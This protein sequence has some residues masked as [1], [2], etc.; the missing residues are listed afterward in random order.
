MH[1]SAGNQVKAPSAV[2]SQN[3][4]FLHTQNRREKRIHMN[5]VLRH[6]FLLPSLLL[7]FYA[8]LDRDLFSRVA[9]QLSYNIK[10]GQSEH[11]GDP[12]SS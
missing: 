3:A 12:S 2:K 7:C 8:L 6:F 10:K 5:C 4:D 1:L 11:D 9:T